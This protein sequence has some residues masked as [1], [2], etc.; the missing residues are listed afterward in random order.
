[1]WDRH[2]KKVV[3]HPAIFGHNRRRADREHATLVRAGH[4]QQAKH[5]TEG[6]M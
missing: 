6:G 5:S 3:D 2:P 4:V 1:M